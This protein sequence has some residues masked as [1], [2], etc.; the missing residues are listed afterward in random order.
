[1]YYTYYA[2]MSVNYKQVHCFL[3]CADYNKFDTQ[4]LCFWILVTPHILGMGGGIKLA[5]YAWID[6]K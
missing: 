6:M 3:V 5:S 2:C 1:M 4:L